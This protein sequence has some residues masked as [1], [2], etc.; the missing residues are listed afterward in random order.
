MASLSYDVEHYMPCPGSMVDGLATGQCG[1]IIPRVI[2]CTGPNR[3]KRCQRVSFSFFTFTLRTYQGLTRSAMFALTSCG[4][5]SKTTTVLHHQVRKDLGTT[6]L[7][8]NHRSRPCDMGIMVPSLT[9]AP[10]PPSSLSH[11]L[12]QPS[13]GVLPVR[14]KGKERC[15]SGT[16]SRQATASCSKGMCKTCCIRDSTSTCFYK[17]HNGGLCP[18]STSDDPFHLP[19]PIPSIPL[20]LPPSTSISKPGSS[21]FLL[22]FSPLTRRWLSFLVPQAFLLLIVQKQK[23]TRSTLENLSHLGLLQIGINTDKNE[24]FDNNPRLRVPRTNGVLSTLFFLSLTRRTQPTRY[25]Y[26]CRIS[27]RGRR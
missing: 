8:V 4:F 12:I 3:E 17:G 6:L 20:L 21:S 16:C 7:G 9:I 22:R 27:K 24:K 19:G 25:H 10:C 23:L 14:P 13:T 15:G 18:I 26:L 1:A 2:V 11:S 5:P